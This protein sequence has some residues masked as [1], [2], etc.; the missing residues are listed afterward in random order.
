MNIS[1]RQKY[2]FGLLII[3]ILVAAWLRLWRLPVLPPGLWYDEAYNAMDAI[4]MFE[5]RL[6][7]PFLIGNYGREPMFSY[8]GA[9]SMALLGA[10]PYTFRLVAAL[11]GILTVP[12][13]Y[14][15]LVTFFRHDPDRH[16]LGLIAATGFTFSFWYLVISRSGYR[17]V[18]F[19]FFVILTAYLFWRGW[20]ARSGWHFVAAG[21]A[22]GLSQYTYLSAR[23]LPLVFGLFGIAWLIVAE[24]REATVEDPGS[25]GRR[26]DMCPAQ[27]GA[28]K[29]TRTRANYP[30]AIGWEGVKVVWLGLLAMALVSAVVFLP[31]GRFFWQNPHA[32]STRA[33]VVSIASWVTE[34]QV[35]PLSHLA[36]AL[37]VFVDQYD[38]NWRH[39]LVGRPAFDWL[40]IIGFWMGV[41]VAVSRFRQPPYLFLLVGL[42][43][44]WLP[45][46]LSAP[47]VHSL[48]L[49]GM[50]PFYYALLAIGLVTPAGWIAGRLSQPTMA[51]LPKLAALI[52]I[53][54]I[55]GRTTVYDYFVRWAKE[56]IVYDL[57]EGAL[58]DL[59]DYLLTASRT[60][61]I[62]LPEH[63][64][65]H[66]TV[67]L[68]L[69]DTFQEVDMSP[70][71]TVGRPVILVDD[72]DETSV[73]YMWL[74]RD[75]FDESGR[76]SA[77]VSR[78]L[79][80]GELDRMASTQKRTLF[81][82]PR[83]GNTVAGL[84]TLASI[85]PLL[86]LFTDRQPN[87]TVDYKWGNE[88]R[89]IGYEVWPPWLQPGQ[90]PVLNLY[91][92][93]LTDQPFPYAIFLQ[94]INGRGEPVG[95][96]NGLSLSDE[97]RWRRG[98]L[99][100]KQYRLRLEPQDGAETG[101]YLV[102][103]G[104]FE[105]N[106]GERLPIY[107]AD[108]TLLGDQMLLGLF[109]ITNKEVD[110][111][112]PQTPLQ[113]R[114]DDQI[115]LLGYASPQLQGGEISL[116]VRLHWQATSR[117]KGDYTIFVQLLNSQN[118]RVTGWD[119][120]PLAG[121]YPTSRWQVGEI[122]VDEFSLPL[123]ADLPP[124][125]YRLVTGMY[126]LTTGQRLLANDAEGQPLADNMIV[127]HKI[128]VSP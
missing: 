105:L 44:L 20:Q 34:E 70:E 119:A 24:K 26:S 57:Y 12:L 1:F 18:L 116:P 94:L 122:V 96:I 31:L 69:H 85:E 48:R 91:W 62:L 6:P 117:I 23:L 52:L 10:T 66:P 33:G 92:Q 59:T 83:T 126:D 95:Q 45:A 42:F 102:R 89:L 128:H 71:A 67:R 25:E 13:L 123:P 90:S 11:V 104:L 54:L 84:T 64:Y 81:H 36:E 100:P 93:N 111:R 8:L 37:R 35:S 82:S 74:T 9:L 41:V 3:L 50:L 76:G 60:A 7:R 88:V 107:D 63:L 17:A 49:S 98:K 77:Y 101:P 121:Q 114:L 38:P 5:T 99:V 27:G 65:A 127:L 72:P 118:Q 32:F 124:D 112:L 108:G 15:W 68:L 30:F 120:Q 86:P 103:L 4:W 115:E 125:D 43:V 51:P 22:L 29:G 75:T 78:P 80:P 113:A 2:I 106:T 110:P 40:S 53:V 16:W 55:S 47:A 21:V 97:Y 79:R 58:V 14:R 87:Y 39:D 19:P 28:E 73:A 56:P 46:P 61:D 109:Y